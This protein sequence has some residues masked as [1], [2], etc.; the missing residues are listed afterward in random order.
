MTDH[1]LNAIR[2]TATNDWIGILLLAD[3]SDQYESIMIYI[4]NSGYKTQ[5]ELNEAS[6]SHGLVLFGSPNRK[7]QRPK[8]Q[9]TGIRCYGGN[10]FGYI[11]NYYSKVWSI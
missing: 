7:K 5:A 2:M 6:P 10:K 4:E 9:K 8:F 1:I 11:S 3:L